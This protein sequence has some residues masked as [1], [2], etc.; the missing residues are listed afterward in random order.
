MSTPD[1]RALV[2][3]G[4]GELSVRRQCQLLG[5]AHSGI[6]RLHLPRMMMTIRRC[7]GGSTSCSPPGRFSAPG[8]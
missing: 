4:H 6:Y 8:G 1:R 2:D 5:I 3:R 7:C